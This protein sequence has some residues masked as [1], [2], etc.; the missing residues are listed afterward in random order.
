MERLVEPHLHMKI[1]AKLSLIL[2]T[3]DIP[4][5]LNFMHGRS[6]KLR[7]FFPILNLNIDRPS[8]ATEQPCG[9][10][11]RREAVAEHMYEAREIRRSKKTAKYFMSQ[12]LP[13]R[14]C[15]QHRSDS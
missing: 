14:A 10:K 1:F 8:L 7:C 9:P 4:T 11:G 6:N 2:R 3:Y 13:A 12:P 15:D 5:D